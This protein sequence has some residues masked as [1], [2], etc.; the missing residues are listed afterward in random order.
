VNAH[1]HP[2]S[3]GS[4]VRGVLEYQART[5]AAADFVIAPETGRRLSFGDLLRSSRALAAFLAAQGIAAGAHVGLLLPNGLQAVRLFVGVTACGRVL[6]PLSLIAQPAQLAFILGHSDCQAVFV[7]PEREEALRAA[8]AS[9]RREVRMRLFI[10]DPDSALLPGE[11][12]Q[13]SWPDPEPAADAPALLMY[14]SGCCRATVAMRLRLLR[15]VC[16]SAARRRHRCRRL[17]NAPL[18]SAS[19][20]AS[21]KPWV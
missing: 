19:P 7:A 9:V 6:V 18:R 4:S 3:R 5:H 8:L 15:V 12:E 1:D 20:S 21:S 10:V 14:T 13:A 11:S 17:I 16:V 2:D